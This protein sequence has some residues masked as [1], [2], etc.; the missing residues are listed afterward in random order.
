[1]ADDARNELAVE[2]SSPA[3]SALRQLAATRWPSIAAVCLTAVVTLV[4]LDRLAARAA[5]PRRLSE[6]A[7]GVRALREGDPTT[8][9]LASSHA[10]TF[11]A[12]D[13]ELRRRT[14]DRQRIVAVPLEFGKLTSYEWVLNHR[15]LPLIEERTASGAPVRPS[16]R[17]FILA[18]EWWDSTAPV[19]G[20]FPPNIPARA[21]VFRDFLTDLLA[22]GL[23][24]YNR[25]YVAEGWR[26]LFIRSA[27]MQDRGYDRIRNAIRERIRPTD[28]AAL[29]ANY[30]ADV[31][32]WQRMI[33]SGDAK[34]A[35]TQQM[36]AFGR[37]LDSLA[38]HRLDVTVVL[39]PRKP[40]TI[41]ERA[42]ATTLA[43]W[44]AIAADTAAAHGAR[45]LDLTTSTPLTDEDFARDFDHVTPAGNA[46]FSRWALDGPLAFLA[47]SAPARTAP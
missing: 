21:W 19:D 2:R 41:T 40:A 27:L 17:R 13:R 37:M 33:E 10:R 15:I 8:I 38:A 44:A 24:T 6:V 46:T 36:A 42:R 35:D 3:T 20:A 22:H 34:I 4:A 31:Q 39:Y 9:V 7:D 12:V 47:E 43:R 11:E 28:E 14:A 23:T 26:Q 18:T 30:G 25:A 16:L 5:P 32:Y 1:M 45:F 29:A